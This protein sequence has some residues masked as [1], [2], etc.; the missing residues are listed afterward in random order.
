MGMADKHA[1]HTA[2]WVW[3]EASQDSWGFYDFKNGKPVLREK[4]AKA[5]SRAYPQAISGRILNTQF[6]P[7]NYELNVA[8]RYLETKAPHTL[9]LPLKYGYK[10]GYKV[11]CDGLPVKPIS[12]DAFGQIQV[13]CGKEIGKT[14]TLKVV[15]N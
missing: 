4:T 11:T 6:N 1:A 8:F 15:A 2:Q 10:K 14:Y 12:S 13:E 5:T 3:K 9:F 7:T